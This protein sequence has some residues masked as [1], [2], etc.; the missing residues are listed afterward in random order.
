MDHSKFTPALLDMTPTMC[1]ALPSTRAATRAAAD[2]V[3]TRLQRVDRHPHEAVRSRTANPDP[4]DQPRTRHTLRE[5]SRATTRWRKVES[6]ATAPR[7][8]AAQLE[9]STRSSGG[10][11]QPHLLPAQ[12]TQEQVAAQVAESRSKIFR[13]LA[14][15]RAL[16]PYDI[17]PTVLT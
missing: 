2:P 15:V 10:S 11:V 4:P 7:Q 14:A 6:T 9:D 13:T 16:D 12:R 1:P 8:T 5:L 3:L 17:E